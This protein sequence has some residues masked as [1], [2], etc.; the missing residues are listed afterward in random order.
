MFVLSR[1]PASSI[2]AS[3]R[4]SPSSTDSSAS[5]VSAEPTPVRW[6]ALSTASTWEKT[7]SAERSASTS[8]VS[9]IANRS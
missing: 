4:C 2:A 5:R 9:A 7:T 8:A 6:R 3:S 1:V